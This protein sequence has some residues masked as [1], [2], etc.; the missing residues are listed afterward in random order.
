MQGKEVMKVII[1]EIII[2]INKIQVQILQA[3]NQVKKAAKREKIMKIILMNK[4]II[5]P[6]LIK[7]I[8]L[9]KVVNLKRF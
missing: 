6:I 4:I 5:F 3:K 7:R 9:K 2:I 1:M 8:N